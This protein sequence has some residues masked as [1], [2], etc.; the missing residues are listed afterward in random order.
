MPRTIS[1]LS[2]FLLLLTSTAALAL[3][4]QTK[5]KLAFYPFVAKSVDAISYTEEISTQ[6]FNNVARTDYFEILERKKV[7]SAIAQEGVP[8]AAL[9]RETLFAIGNRAGFDLCIIGRV[10]RAENAALI[11]LQV[12]GSGARSSYYAESFRILDFELPKKLQEIAGRIVL[13]VQGFEHGAAPA[14]KSVTGPVG[15]EARGGP[16]SIRLKWSPLDSRQVIGYAIM[17][18]NSPDG[19][20]V[21]I[22]A[23]T[24]PS[25]TDANLKLNVTFHYKVKAISSS[26]IE[27]QLSEAVVGKTSVAPHTP[28][29]M[30]IKNDPSG[31]LLSWYARP[32]AGEDSNLIASGFQI[33]RKARGDKDFLPIAKVGPQTLSYLDRAMKKGVV[34]SYALTSFNAREVESEL[35]STLEASSALV[36]GNL[37][38]SGGRRR[39]LLK[40]TPNDSAQVEGYYVY[41]SALAEGEYR[42]IGQVSGRSGNFFLD[43]GLKDGSSYFYRLTAMLDG[44]ME[45]PPSDSVSATT[46]QRPTPPAALTAA[47]GQ[48]RKVTLSWQRAGSDQEIQGYRLY[49][50][51]SP[52]GEFVKVAEIPVGQNGYTDDRQKGADK[53][54]LTRFSSFMGDGSA[55]LADGTT[56]CY[57]V[58]AFNDVGS[59]SL[60]SATVS[61]TT[62]PAPEAP[63]HLTA[64][65]GQVRKVTLSWEQNSGAGIKEYLVYRGAA[66]QKEVQ[67]LKS[68]KEPPFVDDSLPDGA[69]YL[70]AVKQV[71]ADDLTSPLSFPVDG[72]TKARPAA[73]KAL[74][75]TVVDGRKGIGWEPNPER[76]LALYVVYRKGMVGLFQRLQAVDRNF[77]PLEGLKGKLELR[78]TAEDRDGLESDKSEP[79]L[80]E[81]E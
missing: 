42:R 71:D 50:A 66:G 74:A 81:L 59:E 24:E 77:F 11:D 43:A 37:T 6:L 41:R 67:E 32:A 30:E 58:S 72:V 15:L 1:A 13:K 80:V 57:R 14:E 20:F 52:E 46:D 26:G 73:P 2:L 65:S 4:F 55:P 40:W 25:Y 69:A 28:I 39:V 17:R 33:Y 54:Y 53:A 36:A 12:I 16:R 75:L 38:A 48:P 56:Y 18:A 35:S 61:A 21:Q 31:A 47:G 29:L 51:N 76:D 44:N 70:Y 68:V 23:S 19:S 79:L 60:P 8:L 63:R 34:Y 5:P 7:E 22:A 62:K 78:V 45:T 9:T 10:S 27:C 64:S 49:R 3:D